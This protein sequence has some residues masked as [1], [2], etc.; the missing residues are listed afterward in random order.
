MLGKS[1]YVRGRDARSVLRAGPLT[2]AIPS[3]EPKLRPPVS[4]G[5]S[6]TAKLNGGAVTQSWFAP[7][8]AAG[9]EIAAHT[10]NHQCDAPCCSPNCTQQ[11][12]EA[13]SYSA[14]EVAAYRESEWEPNIEGIES[15]TGKPVLTA[16]WPC[17]CADPR[18]KGAASPY[19]LG[20]RGYA[21]RVAN[22]TWVEDVNHSN[23]SDIYNLASS[24]SGLPGH[25]FNPGIIDRAVSE[26]KWAIIVSHGDCTGI[27]YMAQHKGSL[28][29]APVG[30]VMKYIKVRDAVNVTHYKRN[31]QDIT[32]DIAH[33]LGVFHRVKLNGT[34]FLPVVFDNR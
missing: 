10:I 13:C 8:T 29:A 9:H 11:T 33:N 31:P 28:W 25:P 3:A 12:L 6:I 4:A 32:F 2:T 15:S 5:R 24:S 1:T 26:G 30:E 21:D 14:S 27:D 17:G 34:E 7:Y 20:V 16:A 23:P 22:L 19:F 18:R